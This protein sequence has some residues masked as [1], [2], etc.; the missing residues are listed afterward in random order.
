MSERIMVSGATSGIGLELSKSLMLQGHSVCAVGRNHQKFSSTILKWACEQ[1][2]Q[3]L[4]G[5]LAYDFS[6]PVE[7][8]EREIK[9]MPKV[10]GFVNCAG[11]LPIAPL[12]LQNVEGL[13]DAIN[14]NLISPILFTR[15]L[16]KA[17][18]IEIGGSLVFISSINGLKVGT[19]A[20]AVYSASKAGITGF[21]MSLANECSGLKIRV[22]SIAP[23]TVETP[24][25]EKTKDMLGNEL[26]SNYKSQ[27][28]L[29]IGSVGS[30]ISCI[31]F[32]LS[33]DS[34]WITGQNLVADGG[35][36]LN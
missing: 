31:R 3:D 4:L 7:V 5:W 11:I 1:G 28:P 6:R 13:L 15:E 22:N 8:P 17:G 16:L 9:E 24:M 12:K 10:S 25:L 19:K 33:K 20:H 34:A 21:V 35:Y 32:L 23:G 26:F 29:G 30:V 14:V 2:C 27:Y 36:T 18:K